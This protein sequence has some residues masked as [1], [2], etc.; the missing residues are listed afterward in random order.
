MVYG[1]DWVPKIRVPKGNTQTKVR[2]WVGLGLCLNTMGI[3]RLGTHKVLNFGFWG[4]LPLGTLDYWVPESG[5]TTSE[6]T[7]EPKEFSIEGAV[8]PGL[9]LCSK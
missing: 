4:V 6:Y 3:F 9:L 8:V 2:V 1:G 5:V 7:I